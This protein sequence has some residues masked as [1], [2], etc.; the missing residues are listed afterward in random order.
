MINQDWSIQT[1]LYL[2]FCKTSKNLSAL[3]IHSYRQDLN[4]LIRYAG[5]QPIREFFRE[6]QVYGYLEYLRDL[7]ELKPAT[8]RRRIACARTFARWLEKEGVIEESP[9]LRMDLKLKVP[10]QLPRSL[11]RDHIARIAQHIPERPGIGQPAGSRLGNQLDRTTALSIKLMLATGIRVSELSRLNVGDVSADATSIRI[12]GKGSR[13]RTVFVG[14]KTLAGDIRCHIAALDCGDHNAPLML[15][16]RGGRLSP[17]TLRVRLRRLS[18]D[19]GISP[20]VTPHRFRHTAATTLIEEGVDIRFVQRLLGHSSIATTE[21]YTHVT[22]RSLR[23]A[24]E[25]ANAMEKIGF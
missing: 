2:R 4:E 25:T 1:D 16:N 18:S 14:S 19:L 13:E 9:F 23:T 7:R 10:K 12:F 8:V 22:D 21:L 5:A 3:S 20:H 15:N 17:Q 24:I 6:D 11:G